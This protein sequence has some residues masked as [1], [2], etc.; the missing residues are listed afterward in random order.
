[1]LHDEVDP[2]LVCEKLGISYGFR[3]EVMSPAISEDD[4]LAMC[5]RDVGMPDRLCQG[6]SA[7]EV[8][9]RDREFLGV[10]PI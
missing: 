9:A 3:E 6:I 2:N 5:Y 4:L 8:S 10:L 7:L 1:M